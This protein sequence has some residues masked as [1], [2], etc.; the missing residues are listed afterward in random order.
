MLQKAKHWLPILTRFLG[1]QAMVQIINFAT[2]LILLR[3][4]SIEEYALFIIA[5]LFLNIGS[6]GSDL[7]LSNALVTYGARIVGDRKGLSGL[8]ALIEKMRTKLFVLITLIICIIA[9]F[10][11]RGHE[12]SYLIVLEILIT[13]LLIVWFQQKV[14]MRT[15]IFNIH[16]DS[17]GIFQTS[18]TGALTRL[19]CSAVFCFFFPFAVVAILSVFLSAYVSAW[20]AKKR[21][22]IYLDE[23]SNPD[24]S[25]KEKVNK[26]IYPMMPAAVYYLFQGQI[27]IF[28]ISIFGDTN[29]I[30]ELGAL[31]RFG[32]VFLLIGALNGFLFQPIFS[33]IQNRKEFI[34]K[35]AL[36][37]GILIVFFYL[38]MLS[39]YVKPDWWLLLLGDKYA[40]LQDE[41]PIAFA[42][43]IATYM[44]GMFFA[45]LVSR[46]FTQG[47]NWYV[48]ATLGAQV[49]F[50]ITVGVDTTHNALLFN[51]VSA[52]TSML[53][54]LALVV[55]LLK[56]WR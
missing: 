42:G 55:L 40:N 25:C 10:T 37:M 2:A 22:A 28:L 46:A 3:L 33:R 32:Q 53:V 34:Q 7:N 30:A 4:L 44:Y 48:L 39:A 19:I 51:F 43:P 15:M 49:I 31:T 45:M 13:V 1:G 54:Q 47:Q 56:K 35:S 12:W 6:T 41:V 50:I 16:H 9:P 8:Y 24:V 38:V 21:C 26:Y 27:S 18:M 14:T 17:L 5:N 29:S 36:V 11:I 20:I 52:A 23:A